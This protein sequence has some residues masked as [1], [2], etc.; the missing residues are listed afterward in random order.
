MY[1][2]K[3]IHDEVD[4]GI[5]WRNSTNPSQYFHYV[6]IEY[7]KLRL[8]QLNVNTCTQWNLS[9]KDTLQSGQ[10]LQTKLFYLSW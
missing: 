10:S 5:A 7:I 8:Y 9:K 3:D 1:D 6:Q 2:N 4:R